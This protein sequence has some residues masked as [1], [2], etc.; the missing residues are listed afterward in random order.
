MKCVKCGATLKDNTIF[1]ENCG[2]E[3][4]IVPDYN[5]FEDEYL[6]ALLEEDDLKNKKPAEV[7]P[8]EEEEPKP[9]PQKKKN[10]K[11]VI[12]VIS[13]VV[14]LLLFVGITVGMILKKRNTADYQIAKAKEA[15]SSKEYQVALEYYEKAL[16]FEP[17]NKELLHAMA[18]IYRQQGDF[19]SAYVSYMD[20][21]NKDSG[22]YKAYEALISI[23]AENNKTE[24]II[25]LGKEVTDPSILPLF[26]EY[27]V[28]PP[29]FSVDEGTYEEY[30]IISLSAVKGCEIYYTTDGSD[31]VKKGKLYTSSIDLEE[32]EEADSYVI[33]AVCKNQKGIYSDPVTKK[34]KI[35]LQAPDMPEVSPDGG[36]FTTAT[37]VTITI[38]E[39][40]VAYYTWDGTEP[41]INSE[42]YSAMIE[43]PEGD[44][45]LS[46]V[47]MDQKT[48][49]FS[50]VYRGHF[51]YYP[52]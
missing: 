50:N 49:L 40:C 5:V 33:S 19:D 51:S 42:Q 21:I 26:E 27:M 47:L 44:H 17:D 18:D 10:K 30:Q 20:L 16:E 6:K 46:V 23:L 4:Q 8:G 25:A 39:G 43:V 41:S 24:E 12:C 2:Q 35:D 13:I 45:I 1:C 36:S 7:P 52:D 15:L 31:P 38:P 3:V 9:E 14:L 22:D 34:Y 37:T 32:L 28:V 29:T 11:L 48:E